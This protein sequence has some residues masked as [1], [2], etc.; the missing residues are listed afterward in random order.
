MG[1]VAGSIHVLSDMQITANTTGLDAY[2]KTILRNKEVLAVILRE[3]VT[4]YEGYT[5]KEVMDFI[6]T[7][8]ITAESEVSPGRTNTQV[9]G[10]SAEFIHLNEKTSYFDLAFR[11]KNPVLSKKDVFISLHMDIEP[12]KDYRPGYPVEKRGIYYLA[13]RLSSQLSLTTETTDYGQLEKC[14]SIWICRDNIPK[15][16][17][18]SVSVYEMTNTK[19]TCSYKVK[20]EHY[21]L[22]TL[23]IIKLGN[24]VYNGKKEE[25]Y[26]ELLRFLDTIMSP[27]KEDFMDTVKEY[28]DFSQNKELWKEVTHVTGLGLSIF[29][30]GLIKG[31]EEG[32]EEGKLEG[33]LEATLEGIQALIEDNLEEQIPR[34]RSLE[35]LQRRFHLTEEKAIEYYERFA[36]KV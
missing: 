20:E 22:M 21:N 7:D 6:E 31:R 8:S 34:E 14:Y 28:I 36:G 23:V 18:Y 4:E 26:Y 3:V 33:K 35:K 25:E 9:Q 29:N 24:V 27:H 11:A 13:R 16:A 19:N 15:K 10:D 32:K 17:Q 30:E 12:Q 5:R 1:K 2:S